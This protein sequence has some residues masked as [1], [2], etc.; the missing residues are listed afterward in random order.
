[1]K[2]CTRCHKIKP[3]SEFYKR[4]SRAKKGSTNKCVYTSHCRD[5][6][7]NLYYDIN[8]WRKRRLK[9]EY[10][11]T[12]KEYDKLFISQKGL[13][14]ICGGKA[15]GHGRLGVDHNHKTLKV[16]GLLCFTCNTTIGTIE[17]LGIDN[18]MTYIEK[19]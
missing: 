7:S 17:R 14:A 9:R 5:C 1:M 6:H 15:N 19:G 18:I 10:G 13:C 4:K 8:L 2:K 11:I 16:R 12:P 3:L